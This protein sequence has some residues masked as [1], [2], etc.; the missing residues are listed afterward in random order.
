MAKAASLDGSGAHA[1]QTFCNQ[2]T[3]TYR[4]VTQ[5]GGKI[6]DGPLVLLL[7]A[8][9]LSLGAGDEEDVMRAPKQDL[10]NGEAQAAAGARDNEGLCCCGG[11]GFFFSVVSVRVWE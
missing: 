7:E 2:K 3:A 10:R 8:L 11:H 4:K 5:V 9:E 1:P 6:V